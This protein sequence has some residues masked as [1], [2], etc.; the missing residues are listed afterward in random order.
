MP[1]ELRTR[2]E[3]KVNRAPGQGP[4]GDCH[5]WTAARLKAGYGRI[6]VG[7]KTLS[8]HRV[9]YFL[10]HGWWPLAVLHTCDNPPCVREDHLAA[11]TKA[12]NAADRDAKGR[13]ARGTMMPQA[14]LTP[15]QVHAIRQ[16]PRSQS[17]VGQ[18]YGVSKYAVWRIKTGRGW[19][20]V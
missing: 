10:E 17:V 4:R 8:A 1:S 11:G 18:A 12:T 5:E 2:F 20:H 6:R 13:T 7:G 19:A 14:K 16:D 15:E 9:A 3:R